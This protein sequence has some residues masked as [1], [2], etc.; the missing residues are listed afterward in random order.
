MECAKHGSVDLIVD[1]ADPRCH[2]QYEKGNGVE[3]LARL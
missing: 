1:R 2:M 3:S